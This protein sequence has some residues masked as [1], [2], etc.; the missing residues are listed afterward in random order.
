MPKIAPIRVVMIAAEVCT[1]STSAATAA[2][3]VSRPRRP[4]LRN[5]PTAPKP[6]ASL[7]V[8]IPP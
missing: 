2:A 8:N 5:D 1:V 3:D 4:A 7:I 6:A